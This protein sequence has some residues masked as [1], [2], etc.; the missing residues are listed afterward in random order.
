MEPFKDAKFINKMEERLTMRFLT[1]VFLSTLLTGC[2]SVAICG[3][4]VY[5]FE[6]PSTIPFV[7][8]R[9]KIKRS[10][11]HVDCSRDPE[12]RGLSDGR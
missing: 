3:E 11:D 7:S 5:E 9:F 6:V 1:L 4:R 8:G 2:G 10:S 12:D